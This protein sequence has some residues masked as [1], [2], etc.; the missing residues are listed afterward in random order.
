ML[1][2]YGFATVT[3]ASLTNSMS[4]CWSVNIFFSSVIIFGERSSAFHLNIL[5]FFSYYL[6]LKRDIYCLVSLLWDVVCQYY[7]SFNTSWGHVCLL[8]ECS[9]HE[10]HFPSHFVSILRS[11]I[12]PNLLKNLYLFEKQKGLLFLDN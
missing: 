4:V 11:I 1:Y 12:F 2:Y 6:V 9:G 3:L 5:I 10:R 8:N 7:Q